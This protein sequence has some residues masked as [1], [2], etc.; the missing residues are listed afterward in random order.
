MILL[1]NVTKKEVEKE[2]PQAYKVKACDKGFWVFLTSRE[3]RAW[4]TSR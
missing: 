4:K 2:Y 3:Y 1:L